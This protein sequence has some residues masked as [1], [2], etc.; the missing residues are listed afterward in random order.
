[1]TTLFF[2]NLNSSLLKE[3]TVWKAE[4]RQGTSIANGR[5]SAAMGQGGVTLMACALGTAL[6]VHTSVFS[7][8]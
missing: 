7:P 3:A 5:H 8:S 1:M 6:S 4:R 2:R